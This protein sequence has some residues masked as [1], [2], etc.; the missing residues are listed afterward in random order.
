MS[1]DGSEVRAAIVRAMQTLVML[2]HG[3]GPCND[4]FCVMQEATKC[5]ELAVALAM[6]LA[7]PPLRM[8]FMDNQVMVRSCDAGA[9]GHLCDAYFATYDSQEERALA[10]INLTKRVAALYP[11]LQPAIVGAVSPTQRDMRAD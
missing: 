2:D 9:M 10:L 5:G 6:E 1:K 11:S 3:K 8:N 7:G 4:E